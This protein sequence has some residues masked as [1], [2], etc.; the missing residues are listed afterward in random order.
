MSLTLFRSGCWDGVYFRTCSLSIE[1]A[2]IPYLIYLLLGI[3]FSETLWGYLSCGTP[4]TDLCLWTS[5]IWKQESLCDSQPRVQVHLKM[6]EKFFFNNQPLEML[7]KITAFLMLST[8]QCILKNRLSHEFLDT[9]CIIQNKFVWRCIKTLPS[10][11]LFHVS[12]VL[13]H[14]V[15]GS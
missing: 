15:F 6:F 9:W 11:L 14:S 12:F 5:E 4:G 2:I 8:L 7:G 1:Y 13:T 3:I 10:E